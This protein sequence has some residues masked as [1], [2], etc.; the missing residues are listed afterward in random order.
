MFVFISLNNLCVWGIIY[1]H[2][3]YFGLFFRSSEF[4]I[5]DSIEVYRI[6]EVGQLLRWFRFSNLRVL[7]FK[8]A[9][10]VLFVVL[11]K[12]MFV[13]SSIVNVGFDLVMKVCTRLQLY[14]IAQTR[15]NEVNNYK[16]ITLIAQKWS[17]KMDNCKYIMF[18]ISLDC[19]R[20]KI[21]NLTYFI[22]FRLDPAPIIK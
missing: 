21:N 22:F 19:L 14:S 1:T 3:V 15:S 7:V 17:N 20:M 9:I 13:L 6:R 2:F 5:F 4:F 16:Y 11:C 12:R 8:F 10:S 18:N